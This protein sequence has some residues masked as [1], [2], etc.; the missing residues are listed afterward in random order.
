MAY[1]SESCEV[2]V[3][4]SG[5][6]FCEGP[7]ITRSGTLVVTSITHGR[8]YRVD[9]RGSTVAIA[10]TEGGPNGLTEGPGGLLYVAQSGWH[11]PARQTSRMTGGVQVVEQDGRVEYLTADPIHPNDLCF[12]PD[13]ALYVT[14]PTSPFERNDGRIWR[15]ELDGTA[16]LLR[17]VDW[18]PN[19]IGFGLEDDA[20]YVASTFPE[21]RIYRFPL[22]GS[23][24]GAP[25]IFISLPRGVPDGFAFDVDGNLVL[26]ACRVAGGHVPGSTSTGMESGELQVYDSEGRLIGQW[27]PGPSDL[28][29]NIALGGDGV[30]YV[31]DASAGL[32]LQIG[33]WT[34]PGLPLH[35]FRALGVAPAAGKLVR[36]DD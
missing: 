30:A 22:E 12:G 28:Y 10:D 33:G 20:I 5:L 7:T 16:D 25:E 4:A 11:L 14:D 31:T 36:P 21:A 2:T 29:T 24:L 23:R 26:C 34:R 13:G 19:G 8:L 6:A 15:C 17:S 32:V 27:S 3:I 1:Q 35:P 9:A 18:F